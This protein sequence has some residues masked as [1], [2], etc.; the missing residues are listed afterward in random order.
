MTRAAPARLIALS[1]IALALAACGQKAAAPASGP[2]EAPALQTSREVNVYSARHYDADLAVYEA[3]TRETGI[4]VNLIEARGDELIERLSREAEAS[5]ADLF[6]TA[7]AGILWRAEQR[8]VLQP[9]SDAQILARAPA[10]AVGPDGMWV[11][12]TRRARV[13]VYNKA[14]GLPEGV[15]TY[16]D[17]ADPSLKGMICARPASNIYNQSMVASLIANDGPEAAAA[18]TKGF[19]ANFARKP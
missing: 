14:K 13:I 3:F 19:V 6:I 9:I 17:L 5:P 10:Q 15:K 11:G 1:L 12:L 4:R 18:W 16:E 7:D 8:G 2:G